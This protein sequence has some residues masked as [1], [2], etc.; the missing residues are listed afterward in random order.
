M[1]LNQ[2]IKVKLLESV[3]LKPLSR[4]LV[5]NVQCSII[6]VPDPLFPAATLF[7]TIDTT[8]TLDF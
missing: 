2:I 7:S 3:V 4:Q 6:M 5:C 8:G 1:A